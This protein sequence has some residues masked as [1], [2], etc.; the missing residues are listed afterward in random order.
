MIEFQISVG[1]ALPTTSAVALP[2]RIFNFLW[3][4]SAWVVRLGRKQL[5]FCH[6]RQCRYDSF[7]ALR[8]GDFVT[9][10]AATRGE[11][12][13]NRTSGWARIHYVFE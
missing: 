2:N 1:A 6:A 5:T 11:F 7:A 8:I 3:N 12:K 10:V 9:T 13:V 4:V